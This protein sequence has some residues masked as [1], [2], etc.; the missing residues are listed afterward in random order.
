AEALAE[1]LRRFLDGR[2]TAAR[3]LT[4]G[5]RA[6]RWCR[7]R[8]GALAFATLCCALALAAGLGLKS[9]LSSAEVAPPEAP[10]SQAGDGRLRQHQ[11]ALAISQAGASWRAGQPALIRESL[12]PWKPAPGRDDLRDFTWYWLWARG[13]PPRV[14]RGPETAPTTLAFSA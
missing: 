11:Y 4:C 7:R 5:G 1:D 9:V 2:P 6:A 13:R 3:P 14:L 12:A 8:K 10:T